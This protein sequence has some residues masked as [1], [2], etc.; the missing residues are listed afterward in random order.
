MAITRHVCRLRCSILD[1]YRADAESSISTSAAPCHKQ[2]HCCR[3][4]TTTVQ[5][6]A[7]LSYASL[8]ILAVQKDIRSAAP[9]LKPESRP[10]TPYRKSNST[11]PLQHPNCA[12]RISRLGLR[13]GQDVS[14]RRLLRV[15]CGARVALSCGRPLAD[16]FLVLMLT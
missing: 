11:S 10:H 14:S 5:F 9:C 4:A 15:G 13:R 7:D 2:C 8:W 6:V 3:V 12:S 1:V 16:S